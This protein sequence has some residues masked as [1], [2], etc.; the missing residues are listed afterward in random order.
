M[1]KRPNRTL[2]GAFVVGGIALVVTGVLVFGSGKLL[3]TRQRYVVFFEGSVKG[4]YVGAPVTFRGVK[5]GEVVD[6]VLRFDP[7]QLSVFISTYIEIDRDQF[8]PVGVPPDASWHPS[9]EEALVEKG[10]K[11]RL[12]L[13][14]LVTG[15]LA[16]DIGFHPEEPIRLVG[17]EKR[18]PEIPTIRSSAEELKKK[19]E[20]L[21][22]Q[23]IAERIDKLLEAVT[24]VVQ[25]PELAGGLAALHQALTHLDR[26]VVDLDSRLG[27]LASSLAST[28]AAAQGAFAQAEKTMALNDGVAGE[29]A[30]SAREALAAARSTLAET[31]RALE[32]VRRVTAEDSPAVYELNRSLESMGSLSRSLRSL[33][34]YLDRHPEALLMGKRSDKGE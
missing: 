20:D 28:S 3:R 13:Q 26:L 34:D 22:L 18:Y 1:S 14:S 32:G 21:P 12:E 10:L 24:S 27:P 2:I 17:L 6:I 16:V 15:L 30:S 9:R 25:S 33:V 4:L 29:L 8:K 31:Q 11:A 23:S 7:E 5:I 19:I